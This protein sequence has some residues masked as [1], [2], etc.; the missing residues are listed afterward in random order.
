MQITTDVNQACNWLQKGQ[1]LLY[2]TESV[3]GL[4]CDAWSSSAVE[5]LNQIKDRSHKCGWI[6]L[7]HDIKQLDELIDS[8]APIQWD[9]IEASWPGPTTWVFPMHASLPLWLQGSDQTIAI[10]MTAHLQTRQLCQALDRPL[11]ST[12][13]NRPN[14]T[15]ACDV[16]TATS[17]AKDCD[18]YG[19]LS[20]PCGGAS[21]TIIKEAIS[22]KR[23][24]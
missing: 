21:P 10:R 2:P 9:A 18:L 4:G 3:Y 22:L 5:K 24:R 11:I 1:L 12:S 19:V 16:M 14:D 6:V 8:Q 7:I 23:L 20:G 13:A 17:F 15:P